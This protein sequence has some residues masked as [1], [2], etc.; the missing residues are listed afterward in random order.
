M[1]RQIKPPGC[2]RLSPLLGLLNTFIPSSN[3]SHWG[4]KMMFKLAPF[5]DEFSFLVR[6]VKNDLNVDVIILSNYFTILLP[7]LDIVF[8]IIAVIN[9]VVSINSL[10]TW[11]HII[12][13]GGMEESGSIT[14]H[15]VTLKEW[16]GFDCPSTLTNEQKDKVLD[17]LRWAGGEDD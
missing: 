2:F 16:W 17:S 10:I 7:S 15:P 11:R 4:I 8:V 9:P 14:K 3:S 6:Y 13:A 12:S 5:Q 1:D